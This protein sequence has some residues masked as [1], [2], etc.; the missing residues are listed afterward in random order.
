MPGDAVMA[1]HHAAT[2]GAGRSTVLAVL[3]AAAVLGRDPVCCADPPAPPEGEGPTIED[4]DETL[5]PF[6][7]GEH[8]FRVVV[9]KKRLVWPKEAKHT[10]D[11]DDDETAT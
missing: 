5:G 9:H 11:P 3:T 1:R 6:V 4:L 7:I 2:L 10:F 8:P